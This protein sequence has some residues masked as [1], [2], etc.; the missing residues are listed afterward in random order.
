MPRPGVDVINYELLFPEKLM[1]GITIGHTFNVVQL[2][3]FGIQTEE[4]DRDGN[5]WN[6]CLNS[7]M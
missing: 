2:L 5:V 3:K 6:R 7:G 1:N 4:G